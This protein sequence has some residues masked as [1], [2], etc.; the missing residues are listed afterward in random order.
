M[1]RPDSRKPVLRR[2]FSLRI[3]FSA[4]ATEYTSGMKIKS[5]NTCEMSTQGK[6]LRNSCHSTFQTKVPRNWP[7]LV[8]RV[9]TMGIDSTDLSTDRLNPPSIAL[10]LAA[11]TP[12]SLT[13]SLSRLVFSFATMLQNSSNP[14]P[15]FSTDSPRASLPKIPAEKKRNVI[16]IALKRWDSENKN[17]REKK[18]WELEPKRANKSNWLVGIALILQKTQAFVRN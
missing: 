10:A 1:F 2:Q 7:R 12:L 3:K 17:R 18:G 9:D 11:K 4:D 13:F 15:T 6:A 16:N 5:A 8:R 14:T